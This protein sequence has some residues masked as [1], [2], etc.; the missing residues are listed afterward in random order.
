MKSLHGIFFLKTVHY[1]LLL[2]ISAS[3]RNNN[4]LLLITATTCRRT[5]Q[6]GLASRGNHL[7]S[8][9]TRGQRATGGQAEEGG[10]SHPEAVCQKHGAHTRQL[11]AAIRKWGASR[12]VS[13]PCRTPAL[14]SWVS[15]PE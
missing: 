4:N 5:A 13:R 15:T 7:G 14:L 1:S 2:D 10:G 9:G 12:R 11:P 6:R 3:K 8:S